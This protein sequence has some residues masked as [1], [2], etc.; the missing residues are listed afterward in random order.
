M[1]SLSRTRFAI[2][3]K[4]LSSKSIGGIKVEIITKPLYQYKDISKSAMTK[5]VN[6]LAQI[7]CEVIFKEDVYQKFG[8]IDE[9]IVWYGNIHLLGYGQETETI[10]RID[11]IEVAEELRQTLKQEKQ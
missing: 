11:S 8:S 1:L 5:I 4:H 7:G 10:M 9:R 2:V 6:E 3:K